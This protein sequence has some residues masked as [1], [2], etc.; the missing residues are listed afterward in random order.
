M[1]KCICRRIPERKN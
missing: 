1:E